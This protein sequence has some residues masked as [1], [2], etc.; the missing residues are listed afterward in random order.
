MGRS[1][2]QLDHSLAA[3]LG[4][5]QEKESPETCHQ[6][7][8]RRK[9]QWAV[10]LLCRTGSRHLQTEVRVTRSCLTLC[11][12]M[13]YTVHGILQARMLEWVA[14]PF[15]RGS[16]QPRDRTQVSRIASRFFASRATT[17]PPNQMTKTE[18]MELYH[19]RLQGVLLILHEAE[20]HPEKLDE[21]HT[22][23][24]RSAMERLASDDQCPS[25]LPMPSILGGRSP[26]P[27]PVPLIPLLLVAFHSV[28]CYPSAQHRGQSPGV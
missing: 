3:K 16:S 8:P 13:N 22:A 21:D 25:R 28:D 14:I 1:N 9:R 15:S 20:R 23:H 6:W 4:L 27:D 26:H 11:N 2:S 12:P 19:L 17:L 5:V 7:K 10:S 24:E 18:M